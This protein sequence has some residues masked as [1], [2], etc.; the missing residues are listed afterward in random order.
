MHWSWSKDQI[1]VHA[2]KDLLKRVK[3]GESGQTEMETDIKSNGR[4]K[5]VRK[6]KP[7]PFSL[8]SVFRFPYFVFRTYYYFQSELLRVFR[9]LNVQTV[10][11]L[12]EL[13]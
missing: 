9:V 4:T 8:H 12:F 7:T 2:F 5:D 11:R 3:S 13:S 1:N 6:S 10:G